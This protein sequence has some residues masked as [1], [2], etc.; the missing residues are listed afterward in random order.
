MRWEYDRKE[1]DCTPICQM[2][3]EKFHRDQSWASTHMHTVHMACDA[4]EIRGDSVRVCVCWR[5]REI[6]EEANETRTQSTLNQINCMHVLV[7]ATCRAHIY[8][9][10]IAI[11]VYEG[12]ARHINNL[13]MGIFFVS[14]RLTLC[15]C[16]RWR[17]SLNTAFMHMVAMQKV[18]KYKCFVA[19]Y[20]VCEFLIS[21][22]THHRSVRYRVRCPFQ[23]HRV[24]GCGR[25][26]TAK[27]DN[28]AK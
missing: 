1:L 25:R 15:R 11:R 18:V 9:R 3:A 17:A 27:Q 8:A 28:R 23:F 7:R 24:F 20:S 2:K 19:F 22:K 6:E 14:F 12:I 13:Y 10:T 26:W 21:H 4:N 16:H 5:E